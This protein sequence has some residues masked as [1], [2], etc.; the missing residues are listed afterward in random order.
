MASTN[1]SENS[2]TRAREAGLL[3][4]SSQFNTYF[5]SVFELDWNDGT[6]P[7]KAAAQSIAVS[8]SEM[9]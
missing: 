8:A 9:V 5:A 1:W 2:I 3:I 4:E 6:D 7:K